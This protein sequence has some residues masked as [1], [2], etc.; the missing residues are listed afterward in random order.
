MRHL[1]V[2]YHWL[3]K[4][5]SIVKYAL[6]KCF[7]FKWPIEKKHLAQRNI[8]TLRSH[9]N[10]S[11]IYMLLWYHTLCFKYVLRRQSVH[12]R[13]LDLCIFVWL[14]EIIIPMVC[15]T[16]KSKLWKWISLLK[17]IWSGSSEMFKEVLKKLFWRVNC[18]WFHRVHEGVPF[19]Y[20]A[21]L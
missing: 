4:P 1:K 18:E 7:F 8:V 6:F 2:I 16:L 3:F 13:V 11:N 19:F 5:D 10:Q 20:K 12:K 21:K 15:K 14:S 9:H 17:Y